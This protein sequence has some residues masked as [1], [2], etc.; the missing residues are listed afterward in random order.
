[1]DKN[2]HPNIRM[3][4]IITLLFC[5]LSY[6]GHSQYEIRDYKSLPDSIRPPQRLIWNG[7][8]G[9]FLNQKQEELTLEKLQWKEV[10][11]NDAT[12]FFMVSLQLND[13]V[14]DLKQE[15]I[16]LQ[17]DLRLCE[18]E[19]L[20]FNRQQQELILKWKDEREANDI[21]RDEKKLLKT[22]LFKS[23]MISVSLGLALLTT[24][25]IYLQ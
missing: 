21:L 11:K 19:A 6:V 3:K 18:E 25:Y 17:R 1:M 4:T 20:S 24:T 2:R 12:T 23:R 16:V 9:V 14:K 15:K 7:E 13:Q 8:K 5:V 22:K 10:Y